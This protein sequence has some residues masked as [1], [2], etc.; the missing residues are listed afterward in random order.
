[1]PQIAKFLKVIC[2]ESKKIQKVRDHDLDP[3]GKFEWKP[4]TH[5]LTIFYS[6]MSGVTKGHT[7]LNK[8]AAFSCRFV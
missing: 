1:M 7:C 6:Q 4:Q 2:C 5:S 3:K 8:T